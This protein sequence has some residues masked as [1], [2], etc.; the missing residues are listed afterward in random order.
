M[1]RQDVARARPLGSRG[2]KLIAGR[3]GCRLQ[4]V[5]RRKSRRGAATDFR[6]DAKLLPHQP[7]KLF[8]SVGLG[9]AESMVEMSRN[10]AS[11]GIF[12]AERCQSP[13]QSYAIRASRDRH[14]N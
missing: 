9:A 6:R 3:S 4:A 12:G 13:Q 1:S 5:S 7:D 2:E 10:E 8:V 14:Q 11:R